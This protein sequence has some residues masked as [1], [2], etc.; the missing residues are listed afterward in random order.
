MG[1][2]KIIKQRIEESGARYWASDNIA[3]YSGVIDFVPKDFTKL[4]EVREYFKSSTSLG[5][6]TYKTHIDK[7]INPVY[8]LQEKFSWNSFDNFREYVQSM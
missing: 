5:A 8:K 3:E 7:F 2:S 6:Y 1:I 4:S